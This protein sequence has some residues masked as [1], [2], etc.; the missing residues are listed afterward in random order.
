MRLLLSFFGFDAAVIC[1]LRKRKQCDAFR[2][3]S[4]GTR[5]NRA[6]VRRRSLYE[7][8]PDETRV[9]GLGQRS[10][11]K[12]TTVQCIERIV[13]GEVVLLGTRRRVRHS[14]RF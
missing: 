12:E 14:A 5:A 8:R 9:A 4:A 2:V 7:L 13:S 10:C 11:L 1:E 3:R 6:K